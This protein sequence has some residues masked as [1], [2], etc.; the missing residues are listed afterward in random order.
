MEKTDIILEMQDINIS[1]AGVQILK[2]AALTLQ[3]GKVNILLGENGAGKSTLMKVLTGAYHKDSGTILIDGKPVTITN[4]ADAEQHG[5]SMIYQEF[6][7]V[8]QL[9]VAENIFLGRELTGRGG[10]IDFE[11]MNREAQAVLDRLHVAINPKQRISELGVAQQQM[12]EIAKAL[13]TKARIVIMDEPTAALTDE[14]ITHLFEIVNE[15]KRNG[16]SIIYISH[17]LEE[18]KFVGDTVTTMRDGS[19]IGEIAIEEA[20]HDRL[21]TMMVGREIKD[22]FPHVDV[23]PGPERLRVRHFSGTRFQDVDLAVH[24]GEIVGLAG[25]MGAGR[26]EVARAIFGA[27]RYTSGS[28]TLNGDVVQFRTPADAIRNHVG[29]VTENRRDEGLVMT[30]DICQNITLPALKSVQSSSGALSLK[31][32]KQVGQ[33]FMDELAIKAVNG[34]QKVATLSGGNQQKVVLAKWLE[35]APEVL[36]MDEPTRGI[37]VG[38]K[39]EIYAIMNQ[40]KEKGVGILMISSEL[41]EV[42]GMSDRI[43]VMREGRIAGELNRE[44]ATQ[45][46]IMKLATSEVEDNG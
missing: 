19:T 27:D 26:T 29:F 44:T 11:A 13:S 28:V 30:L 24:A 9:S 16:I 8:P 39:T 38:A 7:L 21:V 20:T 35:V 34:Q 43:M 12:V 31:R 4:A 3:R 37:D 36:I 15:M 5:I 18:F 1:F 40:L 25:L 33:R 41:P 2:N 6:N 17:R 10:R 14:E 46:S 45:A 32:E 22:Q 42:L 23:V